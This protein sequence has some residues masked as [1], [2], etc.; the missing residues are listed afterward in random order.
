MTLNFQRIISGTYKENLFHGTGMK[1][2][3]KNLR[4][5]VNEHDKVQWTQMATVSTLD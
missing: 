3:Y 5:V 1:N 4:D 2:K